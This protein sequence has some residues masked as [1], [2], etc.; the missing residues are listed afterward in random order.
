[1]RIS[2]CHAPGRWI[3]YIPDIQIKIRFG[4]IPD[5]FVVFAKWYYDDIFCSWKGG[6]G[7]DFFLLCFGIGIL[8][9]NYKE[10][11]KRDK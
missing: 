6:F 2:K 1:M 7:F 5:S 9:P 8:I 3:D 11:R 10:L 4:L